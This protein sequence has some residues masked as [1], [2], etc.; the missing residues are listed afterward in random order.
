MTSGDSGTKLRIKEINP[1]SR[2]S[3]VGLTSNLEEQ[4][5][6]EAHK[7]CTEWV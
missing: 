6:E 5:D 3:L 1:K 7:L 2:F 4:A